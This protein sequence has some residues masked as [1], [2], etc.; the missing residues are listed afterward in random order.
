VVT[1]L[2]NYVVELLRWGKICLCSFEGSRDEGDEGDEVN[3]QNYPGDCGK[4]NLATCTELRRSKRSHE[5]S[6]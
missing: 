4:C 1:W 3:E 6:E 5:R 2:C